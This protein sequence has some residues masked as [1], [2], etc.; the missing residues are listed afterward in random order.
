MYLFVGLGNIGKEYENTRHNVG[1]LCVDEIIKKYNFSSLGRKFNANL[2]EGSLRGKRV[3]IIK[4][5]TYMN[6]SGIAVS[7][8]KNFYKISAENIFVFHDDLDL[9]FCRVKCKIGGSDAGHNGVKNI[10]EAIGKN[11]FRIRIGIGRPELKDK[12]VDFVLEKFNEEDGASINNLNCK[13]TDNL[14]LLLEDATD[15]FLKRVN[16]IERTD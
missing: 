14:E 13:I 3:I 9:K 6:R 7:S 1:F 15:E 10:Q 4:P 11:F 8:A 16:Q 12:V 2:Y 5:R